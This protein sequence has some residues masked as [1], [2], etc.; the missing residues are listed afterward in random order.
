[1]AK[2]ELVEALPPAARGGVAVLNADDPAVAAMAARTSARVVTFGVD[3]PADVVARDVELDEFGRARFRLVAPAGVT[4]VE[5]Q[6]VGAH[7]VSNALAASAVALELGADLEQVADVLSEAEPSSRWRMELTERADGVTVINDA[8]NANPESMRAGLAAL[9]AVTG[10]SRRGWAVLGAMGE[11]GEA[12]ASAH[13]E[14]GMLV[15]RLGVDRLLTVGA[16]DYQA[17]YLGVDGVRNGGES[18]VVPDVAAALQVLHERLRPGDVVLVKASRAVGLERVAAGLL[19][20]G[21]AVP[22]GPEGGR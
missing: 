2:G 11:L 15:A 4:D 17:G 13:V 16:V 7:Q 10:G 8:Y 9:V 20:D 6:L 1:V 14:V 19:G 12:S 5:L 21:P 22:D 3:Q 18:M